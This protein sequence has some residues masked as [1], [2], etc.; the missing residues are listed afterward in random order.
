MLHLD[1]II[2]LIAGY[3]KLILL[4]VIVSI[5]TLSVSCA[6]TK[7]TLANTSNPST[8]GYTS[9]QILEIAKKFSPDCRVNKAIE[10][11]GKTG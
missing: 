7:N 3:M 10:E 8:S 6:P 5:I 4:L 2:K 9:E 1:V 11:K